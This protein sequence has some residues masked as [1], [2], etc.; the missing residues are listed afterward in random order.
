MNEILSAH[1][2]RICT[3]CA[4]YPESGDSALI[5]F[6][7]FYF[8]FFD[9]SAGYHHALMDINPEPLGAL[10]KPPEQ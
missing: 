7:R 1:A 8:A 2:C 10:G 3:V 5:G 6:Y 4:Q 9:A